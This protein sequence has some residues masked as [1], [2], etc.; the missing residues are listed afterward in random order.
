MKSR[1]CLNASYTTMGK[2]QISREGGRFEI[3]VDITRLSIL[4][5]MIIDIDEDGDGNDSENGINKRRRHVIPLVLINLSV[6]AI[7]VIFF[8]CYKQEPSEFVMCFELICYSRRKSVEHLLTIRMIVSSANN[9][10]A[11]YIFENWQHDALYIFENRR[12]CSGGACTD[13]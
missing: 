10:D 3:P 6:L 2:T 4:V 7:I 13:R 5:T 8:Q 11:L 1:R 12:Y 9:H